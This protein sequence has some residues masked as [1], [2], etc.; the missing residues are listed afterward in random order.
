MAFGSNELTLLIKAKDEASTTLNNIRDRVKDHSRS[1]AAAGK[2][3]LLAS[4]ALTAGL[5]VAINQAAK[6]QQQMAQVST[7]LDA[8]SMKHM[9][10]FE[11]SI[12][13]MA[14]E[15]G[16]GTD[17]LSNGLY[18][19]LS[20]SI[21]AEKAISVLDASVRAAKAGLTDTGTAAD[22]ITTII[23]AYGLSADKATDVS[24]LLFAIVKRGK[25]TFAELAPNIGKV[26]ALSAKAGL[27][28]ED[29]GATI[30][31]LTRSGVRSE[32]AMTAVRG[33]INGMLK[34]ADEAAKMF[35]ER[36]GM[37][38]NTTSLK[39]YGLV[40]IL[41]RMKKSGLSPEELATMFPNVRALTGIIAAMG[42]ME[43]AT[44]D[45]NLM[46]NRAGLS[47]EAFQKNFETAQTA[48]NKMGKA[49]VI[50]TAEIGEAFLPAVIKVG[51]I[52]S[53]AVKWFISLDK[54]V[55]VLISGSIALTAVLLGVAGAAAM[56][57]S[58]LP[59]LVSGFN[60]LSVAL[61]KTAIGAT[62]AKTA[63]IGLQTGGILLAVGGLIL[64]AKKTYDYID[65]LSSL[66]DATTEAGLKHGENF[67]SMIKKFTDLKNAFTELVPEGERN[68]EI[69]EKMTDNYNQLT[70]SGYATAEQL[71][72]SEDLL[73]EKITNW[74]G[75]YRE[76]MTVAREGSTEF[77]DLKAQELEATRQLTDEE[78]VMFE[79]LNARVLTLDG[80]NLQSKLKLLDM[81]YKKK[82]KVAKDTI[83]NEIKLN[84]Y[85]IKLNLWRHKEE[86]SLVEIERKEKQ[87]KAF[88]TAEYSLQTLQTLLDAEGSSTHKKKAMII[89]LMSAELALGIMR[90]W[91]AEAT[92]G[93]LG[94]PLAIA[95]T[96]ALVANYGVQMHKLTST[97]GKDA[98]GKMP[99]L[100][101]PTSI[102]ELMPD[103]PSAAT[104]DRGA[105]GVYTSPVV[106]GGAV[107]V[108]GAGGITN[109]NVGGVEVNLG[110]ID[111]NKENLETTL[112]DIGE[113][114]KSR[115]IEAVTMAMRIY[116]TGKANEG[117]A[118]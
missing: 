95:G 111:I 38:M 20:A 68:T 112:R 25:L 100:L 89:T 105:D 66:S 64:I 116:N 27:S 15:F 109:I 11:K 16:E 46:V 74:I 79:E 42:D 57:I 35:E 6:F 83:K 72:A 14:L 45:Y 101:P 77:I 59:F 118:V 106:T 97:S 73:I 48:L 28:L 26:A 113:A 85:M 33:V 61:S 5:G 84:E 86:M 82:E 17:T 41:S 7:M 67:S 93:A 34:P 114:V 90:M 52:I 108:A 65:A 8:Q 54:W 19:I 30:A 99:D 117:E 53:N 24:D 58:K 63:L 71:A 31:T 70:S 47:Q 40:E 104:I 55:K 69:I 102:P 62:V 36:L 96:A 29:L 3:M 103:Y 9:P 110:G 98:S 60:I 43:G 22:A 75:M 12:K 81:E 37:A 107:S 32:A 56:I 1:F 78:A 87:A 92:K 51:A 44:F 2:A 80:D 91:S 13:N 4:A 23:N 88:Q 49:M 18:N 39:A 94:I 115:T 50:L 21:P 76:K 10:K